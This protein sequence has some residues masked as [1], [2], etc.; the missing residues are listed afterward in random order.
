MKKITILFLLCFTKLF[1]QTPT[2]EWAGRIGGNYYDGA[3]GLSVDQSGNVYI[4]GGYQSS[5][6]LDIGTGNYPITGTS[7]SDA[8]LAKYNNNG[9]ILWGV[10]FGIRCLYC[11]CIRLMGLFFKIGC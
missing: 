9:N 7:G 8:F 1:S 11:C 6:D 3:Q 5:I 2:I 10:K 4:T